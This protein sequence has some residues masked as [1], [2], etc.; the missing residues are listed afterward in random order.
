MKQLAAASDGNGQHTFAI[1][2]SDHI[3]HYTNIAGAA[4]TV[5]IPAEARIVV[6]SATGD[7]YARWDGSAAVIP[8]SNIV[9]GS[10]S[11]CN[12]V[13]RSVIP[14]RTFSIIANDAANIVSL[15]FYK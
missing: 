6:F 15:A 3:F 7:F 2:G 4:Q 12:P 14:G 8:V 11:E 5:T 13:A 1:Q 9:D 10:G